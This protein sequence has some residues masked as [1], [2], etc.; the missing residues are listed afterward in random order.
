MNYSQLKLHMIISL[1]MIV[2]SNLPVSGLK[3]LEVKGAMMFASFWLATKLIWPT[4][5]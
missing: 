1:Q 4:K 3:M 5:G 2:H